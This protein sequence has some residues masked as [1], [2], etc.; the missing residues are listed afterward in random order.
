[1]LRQHA[2]ASRSFTKFCHGVIHPVRI[3]TA[4]SD[5]FQFQS[6][7]FPEEALHKAKRRFFNYRQK[8]GVTVTTYLEVFESIVDVIDHVEGDIGNDRGLFNRMAV[9]EQVDLDLEADLVVNALKNHVKDKYLATAFI[10]EAD[11]TRFGKM[12]EDMKN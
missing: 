8:P 10:L 6:Q 11:R 9:S 3:D 2:S 1:M 5:V 7:S 4:D 12:I